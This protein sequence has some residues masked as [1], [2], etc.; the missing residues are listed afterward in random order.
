MAVGQ[1]IKEILVKANFKRMA[2]NNYQ[3]IIEGQTDEEDV[4]IEDMWN[5]G[6]IVAVGQTAQ[7]HVQLIL[8]TR[9]ER[10]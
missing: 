9:I 2:E 8:V 7:G 3:I 1:Q 5:V 10:R 6:S 4:I